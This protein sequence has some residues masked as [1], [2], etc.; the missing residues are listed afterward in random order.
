MYSYVPATKWPGHIVLPMRSYVPTTK[1]PGH[2]VLPMRSYVPTT[3][4]P[5]YNLQ[6]LLLHLVVGT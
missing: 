6:W 4:W 3:K 2:I 1:W 5:T